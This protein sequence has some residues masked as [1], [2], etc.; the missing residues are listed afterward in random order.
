MIRISIV[1]VHCVKNDA[2]SNV[3][4]TYSDWLRME[5]GYCVKSYGWRTEYTQDELPFQI[6]ESPASLLL[7][8]H[9]QHSNII[10]FQYGIYF[11]TIDLIFLA[12][13]HAKVISIFHNITPKKLMLPQH[14]ALIDR[15]FSQIF[16]LQSIDYVVCDSPENL[17]ELRSHNIN[18]PATILPLWY[19]RIFATPRYKPS[20]YD[21]IIRLVFVGR[22]VSS[23]G[24]MDL[25][26]ALQ[27]CLNEQSVLLGNQQFILTFI[28]NPNHVDPALLQSV[29]ALALTL[30]HE[31]SRYLKVIFLLN[32]SDEIKFKELHDAD[33]FVLPSYHEGF[34]VPILEALSSGC[35]IVSNNNSN[36][37]NVAGSDAHLAETGNIESFAKNMQSAFQKVSAPDW[38]LDTPTSYSAF[39]ENN[40]THLE[41]F[42]PA[43]AKVRLLNL[44]S[45]LLKIPEHEQI[46]NKLGAIDAIALANIETKPV[47]RPLGVNAVGFISGILGLGE[48]AR[49]MIHGLGAT[50]NL[51]ESIDYQLTDY[52]LPQLPVLVETSFAN[53]K[54]DFDYAFTLTMLNPT[55]LLDAVKRYGIEKFYG[56]FNI[57]LWYWELVDLIP[58]WMPGFKAIDELWVT[59]DYIRDNMIMCSPVPV[60]KVIV[61][62][63]IDFTKV[64]TKRKEFDLPEN[65]FLFIFAFDQNSIMARKNP[66][67]VIEAYRKAFG[68]RKDVGLVI[69]TINADKQPEREAALRELTYG[70]NAYF[71]DG[72][73]ERY[74][75]FSLYACCDSLVSLHRAEGLGMSIAEAM[76]LG[77]P[78]IATGYS[79]NMEF[80][81]HSN[82]MPVKYELVQIE[83]DQHIY[84]QGQWWAEPDI[85]D[86]VA[87]MLKLAGDADLCYAMGAR[88][89]AHIQTN[90]SA[91]KSGD[92][93][94]NR[95]VNLADKYGDSW[96]FLLTE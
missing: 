69:K 72:E 88:A 7:D 74:K 91:Q 41:Q 16:N 60:H 63:L 71:F 40:R 9:F 58:E 59:T 44:M 92:S 34:C 19:K 39:V 30:E 46:P 4:K 78:V 13:L 36:I 33:I 11:S 81:N 8:L 94:R 79:G 35:R 18:T 24:P 96:N 56:R 61:P 21:G 32:V 80:M 84:R 75:S 64:R 38:W 26:N 1:A 90:F 50:S 10:I 37:P 51:T 52:R 67:A 47:R 82:S 17:R 68:N 5:P 53:F 89:K 86:A 95:I 27:M 48:A 93:M 6:L 20:Y 23:K 22:T 76:L 3:M 12:P 2:M 77:K 31:Y 28:T 70:L 62:I 66:M 55:E 54:N 15:S 73:M 85:E 42:S 87:C 65:T 45:D 14:H 25:L 57:G 83:E 43:T 29:K 49:A